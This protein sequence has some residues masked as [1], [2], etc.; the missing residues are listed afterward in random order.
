[1]MSHSQFKMAVQV[2]RTIA[3]DEDDQALSALVTEAE[4]LLAG[5]P[6]TMRPYEIVMGIEDAKPRI[7]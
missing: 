4:A 7:R 2:L 3:R 5:T 6:T 1:M